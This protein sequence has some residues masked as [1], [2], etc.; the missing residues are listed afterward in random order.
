MLCVSLKRTAD[1]FNSTNGDVLVSG[2]STRWKPLG[3]WLRGRDQIVKFC[4]KKFRGQIV[5]YDFNKSGNTAYSMLEIESL[6]LQALSR[7]F[8]V[9]ILEG[10]SVPSRV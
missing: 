10:G 7:A 6:A 4:F 3:V 2:Q 1:S 8:F 5:K 9:V